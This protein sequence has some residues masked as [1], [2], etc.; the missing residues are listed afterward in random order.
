MKHICPKNFRFVNSL[1]PTLT[2][3][4]RHHSHFVDKN[5]EAE[6][7]KEFVQNQTARG[8]SLV[9]WMSSRNLF[10]LILI[11]GCFQRKDKVVYKCTYNEEI[12]STWRGEEIEAQGSK[13]GK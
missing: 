2:L 10:L 13:V 12:Q 7:D 9:Y 8:N 3:W 6:K 5:T 4:G 1:N 11:L